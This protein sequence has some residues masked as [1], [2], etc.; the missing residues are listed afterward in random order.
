VIGGV[1]RARRVE[2]VAAAATIAFAGAGGAATVLDAWYYALRQPW[3]KPPDWAFGPAWTVIFAL[4]AWAAVSAWRAA[5]D[6]R[7]RRVAVSLFVTNGVLNLMWSVLFFALK[8]P[9]WAL[10][11]V[12]FLW[13]SILAIMLAVAPYA[14][15]AAG[16]LIPYLVWVAYAASINYGV[17]SLNGPF[18]AG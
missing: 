10:A 11:Q 14:A 12:A 18:G 16:L 2:L 8:R 1:W 13:A 7:K 6:A 5:P 4:T 9:D 3:W 17:V 15:K